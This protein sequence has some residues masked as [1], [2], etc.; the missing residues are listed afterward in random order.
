MIPKVIHYCWF[1]NTTK[2]QSVIDLINSWREILPDYT[3]IEW[4]ESNF[5]I[6]K[7]K[8][9]QEAYQLK[10][11]AF[12]SDVC[13]LHCLIEEGGIYLDTDIEVLKN[14][15][16]F[17]KYNSFLG[18]ERENFIGTGVIG[19]KADQDWMIKFYDLYKDLSFVL[20]NNKIGRAHV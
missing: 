13:R 14:F 17:L 6:N 20:P 19:S 7:L 16:P 2:P 3:I 9:T 15:D 18:E 10:K 12:V 4:N 1:G 11:F 5:D 8:Y